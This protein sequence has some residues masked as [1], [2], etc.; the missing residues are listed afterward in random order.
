MVICSWFFDKMTLP[1]YMKPRNDILIEKLKQNV[2]W[3][4][5]QSIK[6]IYK[7]SPLRYL[8]KCKLGSV[9][10]FQILI[11]KRG[12]ALFSYPVSKDIIMISSGLAKQSYLMTES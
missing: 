10:M 7:I 1:T 8:W 9:M 2:V 6:D 4:H 5:L 11:S 12:V 3:D